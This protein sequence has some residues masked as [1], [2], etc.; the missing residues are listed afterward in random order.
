LGLLTFRLATSISLQII[1]ACV[2][3]AQDIQFWAD[4]MPIEMFGHSLGTE[5]RIRKCVDLIN[6]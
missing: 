6:R 1:S 4:E 2:A 3:P 5:K